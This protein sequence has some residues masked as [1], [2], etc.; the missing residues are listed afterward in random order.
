VGDDTERF[1]TRYLKTTHCDLFF[2]DAA[3]LVEGPAEKMLVP[4]FI[5]ENNI[6]EK[7]FRSYIT[8]LEIGGS[9]AHKLLPLVEKLGLVTL[10]ITDLDPAKIAESKRKK[11]DGS[12]VMTSQVDFPQRKKG[13]V[14]KNTVLKHHIPKEKDLDV[15]LDLS[16]ESK[17]KKYDSFFS[18][19]VAYQEPIRV[20]SSSTSISMEVLS[21]TFENALVFENYEIFKSL[22]GTGFIKKFKNAIENN[23]LEDLGEK[24]FN[25]LREDK[26]GK[27]KFSLDLLFSMENDLKVPTYIR[28]GLI[29]LQDQLHKKH[30]EI[31]TLDEE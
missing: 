21:S 13:M 31:L 17:I 29:W 5:R 25:I 15:L 30:K 19:R 24:L 4:Y 22:D 2:A 18:I 20:S 8:I 16:N 23:N 28:E 27:A 14:T 12:A 3:I 7:L 9:H 26:N 1:V 6:Y 10:I 11:K